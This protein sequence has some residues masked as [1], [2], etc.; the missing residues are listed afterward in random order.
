[1]PP[2]ALV[3][4]SDALDFSERLLCVPEQG[5][6]G[7]FEGA[8]GIG[9][10]A[11]IDAACA[12][13]AA[14]DLT[15]LRAAGFEFERDLAYGVV[16]QLF[17]PLLPEAGRSW[18][19]SSLARPLGVA[20]GALGLGPGGGGG[21]HAVR[22]A[23][24]SILADHAATAPILLAIDDLE[25]ADPASLDFLRYLSHCQAHH[26]VVTIAALNPDNGGAGAP[27]IG[28]LHIQQQAQV[29]RLEPLDANGVAELLAARG[30]AASPAL[31][32]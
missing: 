15:V 11:L 20:A 4:R 12:M 6:V 24:V 5:A 19:R 28:L 23:L 3:Q 9:K 10:S 21:D 22:H 29:V 17:D 1:M 14:R 27:P 8:A 25:L 2:P 31:C 30:E 7:V 18:R 26:R 32:A 16:R 13:G